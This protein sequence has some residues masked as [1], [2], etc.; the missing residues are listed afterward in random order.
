M[1]P[2]RCFRLVLLALV[3]PALSL[4]MSACGASGGKPSARIES[5]R[6][7]SL[8]ADGVQLEFGVRVRNPSREPLRVSDLALSVS[9]NGEEFLAAQFP[10][11]GDIRAGEKRSLTIPATISY[12]EVLNVLDAGALGSVVPYTADL[13]LH[14]EGDTLGPLALPMRHEGELPIPDLPIIELR[15]V[16]W[17]ESGIL[18]AKGAAK[19]SITN[20]NDFRVE[21]RRLSYRLEFQGAAIVSGSL[22]ST[23]RLEPGQASELSIP[24]RISAVRIA[25]AAI[26]AG[27]KGGATSYRFTGNMKVWTRFGTIDAP[28]ERGWRANLKP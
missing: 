21:I 14:V 7:V 6:F 1:P 28:L 15:E 24:I 4:A 18:S 5:A 8:N 20:T 25:A 19:L 22:P 27:R 17:Q 23:V 13:N 11:G 9:S 12:P 10:A 3:L 26:E 16:D 2:I